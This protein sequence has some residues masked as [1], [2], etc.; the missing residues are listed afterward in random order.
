ME[1][2]MKKLL[3][4]AAIILMKKTLLTALLLASI[5]APALAGNTT[6]PI[7]FHGTWCWDSTQ[8]HEDTFV[9]ERAPRPI[10]WSSRHFRKE[11]PKGFETI[12]ANKMAGQDGLDGPSVTCKILRTTAIA[13][14]DYIVKVKCDA[15][16]FRSTGDKRLTIEGEKLI[17]K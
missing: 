7:K 4:V 12:S 1:S 2:K 9:Y 17:L 13:P 16:G 14:D 15:E 3:T 5:A 10:S 11:C 6:L 8:S